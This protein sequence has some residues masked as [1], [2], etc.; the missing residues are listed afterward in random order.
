MPAYVLLT[1]LSP[2]S[3]PWLVGQIHHYLQ[4]AKLKKSPAS[5]EIKRLLIAHI[6]NLAEFYG[7]VMGPRI[8]RKH[9]GWYFGEI[10]KNCHTGSGF[11][12]EFNSLS[13][14]QKQIQ[15]I[16]KAF[17][18]INE[19][20]DRQ[21]EAGEQNNDWIHSTIKYSRIHSRNHV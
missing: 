11:L 20:K 14:S 8:A 2:E 15:A 17:T 1:R 21:P 3:Q 5:G 4:T 19:E 10:S 7:E 16:E 9:V 12:R 6:S 18:R 13:H